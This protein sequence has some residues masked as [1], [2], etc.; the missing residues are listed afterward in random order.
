[1]SYFSFLSFFKSKFTLIIF[2]TNPERVSERGSLQ[3]RQEGPHNM[4]CTS[5]TTF[6]P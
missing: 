5:F 1:M 6:S 4:A 3:V 2:E